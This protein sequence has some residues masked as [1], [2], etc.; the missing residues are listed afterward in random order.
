M[1][2]PFDIIQARPIQ[3]IGCRYLYFAYFA[4]KS[5]PPMVLLNKVFC[6]VYKSVLYIQQISNYIFNFNPET[7][8]P[9]AK[10]VTNAI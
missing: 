5:R 1:R 9:K 4:G 3:P 2:I 7:C 6:T 8:N 10:A